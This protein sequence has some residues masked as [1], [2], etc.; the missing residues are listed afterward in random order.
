MTISIGK[1]VYIAPTAVILGDVE[2]SD[3]VSVFDSAVIRGDINT[4]RIGQDSNVQDNV[5]I[6]TGSGNPTAI[7]K[8]VSIGHNAVVHGATVDDNVII[9]MASVILNGA[10][11]RSGTVVA[12]GSVVKEK[13]ESHENSLLAGIPAEEKRVSDSLL[14]YAIANG[15]SYQAIRDMYLAGKVDR[16]SGSRSK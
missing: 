12:A 3:G 1:N 2:I 8:N 14:E 10:H 16:I 11:I 4:I 5:T 15:K 13:F 9:G 7:G 6:H